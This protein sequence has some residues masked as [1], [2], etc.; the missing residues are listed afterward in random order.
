MKLGP[1]TIGWRLLAQDEIEE[2]DLTPGW[3]WQGFMV[4]I[5]T[6]AGIHGCCLLARPVATRCAA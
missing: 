3:Q 6:T 4:E 1:L 2:F 5:T